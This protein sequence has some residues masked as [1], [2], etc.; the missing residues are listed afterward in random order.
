MLIKLNSFSSQGKRILIMFKI[1]TVLVASIFSFQAQAH[2]LHSSYDY[3]PQLFHTSTEQS[4]V[5]IT[6][7][8]DYRYINSNGIPNHKTGTF[9]NHGNPNSISVQ[10]HKYRVP[11][12]PKNTNKPTAKRGIIGI[13]LNG[14]PFEPGTA[15][16]WN[17]DRSS[18][19]N[20]EALSGKINLG[21]DN[22]NAHVHPTGNYHYHGIP[23]ALIGK[24]LT[25][26]GSA[27]DGFPIWAG[28]NHNYK[29]GYRLKYGSRNSGPMGKYDGTFTTDYEY[30]AASGNLD[31][32]NGT[33]LDGKYVYILTKEFPHIPRCLFGS[34]DSSFDRQQGQGRPPHGA[35]GNRPPPHHKRPL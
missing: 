28:R 10:N 11:L 7:D 20:Y 18:G 15:E 14:I 6:K 8:Q 17:N 29:S 32:C 4:R 33:F 1:A 12:R 22:N 9:P 3:T 2:E 31:I 25:H 27:A 24:S 35:R 21:L 34:A 5:S 26:V 16:F 30:S 23:E 19:W 13:A